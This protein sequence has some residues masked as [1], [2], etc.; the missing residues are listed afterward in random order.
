MADQTSPPKSQER[1]LDLDAGAKP[2]IK[3]QPVRSRPLGGDSAPAATKAHRVRATTTT[4]LAA[5]PPA[6]FP[7]RPKQGIETVAARFGRRRATAQ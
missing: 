7:R 3:V 5:C 4:R 2:K 6:R 1:A